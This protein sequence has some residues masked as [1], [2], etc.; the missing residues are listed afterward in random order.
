[1]RE[2][3]TALLAISEIC[4]DEII[5]LYDSSLFMGHQGVIKPIWL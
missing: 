1:M 5:T 2:K 3:E 4:A